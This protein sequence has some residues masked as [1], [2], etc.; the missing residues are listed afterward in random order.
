MRGERDNRPG[1]APLFQYR[2]RRCWVVC[3]SI[4]S[5][6]PTIIFHLS[7]VNCGHGML[8]DCG[9]FATCQE[10]RARPLN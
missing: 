4:A 2:H 3:L 8:A 1:W 10:A 6:L 9:P 7:I 5:F